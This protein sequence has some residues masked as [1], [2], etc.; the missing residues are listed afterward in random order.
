[1]KVDNMS[2]RGEKIIAVFLVLMLICNFPNAQNRAEDNFSSVFLND[3]GGQTYNNVVDLYQDRVGFMWISLFG[4]GLVRYDGSEYRAFRVDSP[5]SVRNNYVTG[6]VQDDFD[7]LW[8][9]SL[10]GLDIIDMKT[11]SNSSLA[12]EF[13]SSTDG[14]FCSAPVKTNDGSIWYCSRNYIHRVSFRQ[15]GQVASRDSVKCSD[16]NFDLRLVLSEVDSDS[17]VWTLLDGYITKVKYNVGRGFQMTNVNRFLYFGEDIHANAI[18]RDGNKVWIGTDNGLY[19][20]DQ[21]TG[22]TSSFFD[23]K[24]LSNEITS[25][26]VTADGSV[27]VGTLSGLNLYNPVRDNFDVCDATVN[28]Y[29]Y[30]ALAGNQVRSLKAV[31]ED[32]WVG[33]DRDGITVLR[34]KHMNVTDVR[35]RENDLSSLPDA[36]ILT[37]FV[38][39]QGRH[40]VGTSEN[41]FFQRE[42]GTYNYQGFNTRNSGLKHNSVKAMA[43]D[44]RGRI[45][46]G[47]LSGELDVMD[48]DKPESVSQ[49][50]GIPDH[51]ALDDVNDLE[52]DGI[53]NYMWVASRSGLFYYDIT[54]STLVKCQENVRICSS[55]VGDSNDNLWI[56]HSAGILRI[57]MHTRELKAHPL[58]FFVIAAV[59]DSHG[60]LWLGS[61]DNGLFLYNT[62]TSQLKR[63]STSDGLA[64]N[65]VRGLL[66]DGEYLWITTENGLSRMNVNNQELRSFSGYDGLPAYSYCSNAVLKNPVSNTLLFGHMR[67]LT[68]VWPGNIH[69]SAKRSVN[70]SFTEGSCGNDVVP[71]A[72]VDKVEMNQ[73]DRV[74]S[75]GF[76]DFSYSDASSIQFYTRLYPLEKEWRKVPSNLN[77]VTYAGLHGGDYK[78]Q[79]KAEDLSGAVLGETS[80]DVHVKPY[81]HNTILFYLLLALFLGLVFYY[82]DKMRTYSIKKNEIRLQAEVDKQTKQLF[83]Q[84]LELEKKA[85]ELLEQ[86]RILLKQN[87]ALAGQKMVAHTEVSSGSNAAKDAQFVEKI[88]ETIRGLYKDPDLDVPSFCLAAGMS[89]TVLN[90]K[91]Q[92]TFGQSIA[93]FIRTYRLNVAREILMNSAHGNINISEVAYEIGFSDPKYFTRCFSKEFGTA[94][95]T[96]LMDQDSSDN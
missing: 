62:E 34:R 58:P 41:G 29:G 15:N 13:A 27:A 17:S 16:T 12:D 30:R 7:R 3:I 70:V 47:T 87:E 78:L 11:L 67:G 76:A 8:V 40:W 6:S 73:K 31:G 82:I 57:N 46:I 63:F 2:R 26:A 25:I 93:Q 61:F 66:P 95:S 54:K 59:F 91:I 18:V 45:W 86:N 49:V 39:S 23:D 77:S 28:D 55:I 33:T 50:P 52:Y 75:A 72:Y 19:M 83:E 14:S 84:K 10:G 90:M 69:P 80:K 94:P 60:K 20:I 22:E 64:D 53:N 68:L 4:G 1:M 85:E 36:Q 48:P 5:N 88:M 56:T 21:A 9:G 92:E 37:T 43:E 65:R 38:D 71:L 74:L 51:I 42:H 89:R 35:H 44:S 24:L 79:L 96:F 32:L 81:F